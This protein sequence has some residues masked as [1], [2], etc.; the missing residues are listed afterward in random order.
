MNARIPEIPA[1]QDTSR[2]DPCPLCHAVQVVK[3]SYSG[4]D[5]KHGLTASRCIGCG[6]RTL[7]QGRPRRPSV[8]GLRAVRRRLSPIAY[9]AAAGRE[10]GMA[11]LATEVLGRRGQ[12][13]VLFGGASGL[14]ARRIAKLPRVERVVPAG[15]CRPGP[16]ATNAT[17]AGMN[18]ERFDVVVATEALGTFLDPH[19]DFRALFSYVD[20]EGIIV[21]AADVYGLRDDAALVPSQSQLA[22]WTPEL[23]R[24]VART[25]GIY[26]D[27]R[28]PVCAAGGVGQR[29]RYAIFSPSQE[30]MTS[31]AVWFGT[32]MYAPSERQDAVD[33]RRIMLRRGRALARAGGD[34][35]RS[36]KRPRSTDA[37]PAAVPRPASADLCLVCGSSEVVAEVFTRPDEDRALTGVSCRR[38]RYVAIPENHRDYHASGKVTLL[39]GG[40]GAR[41]GTW[42]EPGR[43]FGMA[44]LGLEVLNR[45]GASVLMYG[46]GQSIDNHHVA[47]LPGVGRVAIG[48]LIQL[49]HDAEFIN[50]T[51]LATE[52]FD[53]VVASEVLEHLPSPHDNLQNL[54]SYVRDD[55][56]LVAG[57]NI[58]DSLPLVKVAYI[59]IGGHV[60]YWSPESLHVMA[61][62]FGMH[63][64]FRNPW[65][66]TGNGGRRKK[67]IVFSRSRDV[68]DALADWFGTNMYAPSER[69]DATLHDKPAVIPASADES[70]LQS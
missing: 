63:I 64:D 2:S 10:T 55:G 1:V 48:D 17:P 27:Y 61:D 31:V 56:I 37:A 44:K 43:E 34:T 16:D 45:E 25:H 23:L 9:M 33:L 41:M 29:T 3:E 69:P 24:L 19:F 60:S 32:R 21:A 47:K 4:P 68:M 15:R 18:T 65:C 38:C 67:Y 22:C 59:R 52:Q 6:Y 7:H 54:F 50:T 26:V 20:A 40:R 49:R 66:A 12:N 62:K 36:V 70:A 13:V 28:V 42:D 58:R 5:G 11:K 30:V 57:T 51:G 8:A 39:G 53:V 35:V 46:A 14:G